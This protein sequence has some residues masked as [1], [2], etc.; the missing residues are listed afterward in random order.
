MGSEAVESLGILTLGPDSG[1]LE[2]WIGEARYQYGPSGVS[3]GQISRTSFEEAVDLVWDTASAVASP[4]KGY[5]DVVKAYVASLAYVKEN[6]AP[7]W[8]LQQPSLTNDSK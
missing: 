6:P 3:F 8:A 7:L 2:M 4:V 1:D 5:S